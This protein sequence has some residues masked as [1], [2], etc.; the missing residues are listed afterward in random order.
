MKKND[1]ILAIICGLA[2]AWVAMD[3]FSKFGWAFFVLFP[4][5]FAILV[6]LIERFCKNTKVVGQGI[7]HIFTGALADVGDIKIFQLLFWIFPAQTTIKVISFLIAAF[8]KYFGNKYWAFSNQSRPSTKEI[9]QF[10]LITLI[11]LLINV[12]TFSFFVKINI[13]MSANLWREISV[14]FA[15][16]ITA[17]WNFCGYKFIVFKK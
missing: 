11:G 4:I 16:I 17:I 9:F 6:D 14:I 10:L 8:V 1:I 3:L 12:V 5:L 7:R 15:L 2:V 13:E